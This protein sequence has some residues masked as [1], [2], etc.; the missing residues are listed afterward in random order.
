[1][2]YRLSRKAEDDIIQIYLTGIAE[3]GAD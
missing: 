3:F 2:A 1:M